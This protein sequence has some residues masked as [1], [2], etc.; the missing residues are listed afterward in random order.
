MKGFLAAGGIVFVSLMSTCDAQA[1]G[2]PRSQPL[3]CAGPW[4][5]EEGSLQNA[6]RLVKL[7]DGREPED[8][9]RCGLR[10]LEQLGEVEPT[11]LCE[12]CR[13]EYVGLLDDTADYLGKAAL[14]TQSTNFR[15]ALFKQEIET[16]LSLAAFLN[17]SE[18]ER[19]IKKFWKRNFEGLGDAL[20]RTNDAGRFVAQARLSDPGLMGYRSFETWSRAVRS[21]S[22]WNFRSAEKMSKKAIW[23]NT[24]SEDCRAD[25][26]RIRQRSE[27]A[28]ERER[29]NIAELLDDRLPRVEECSG[30]ER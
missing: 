13:A 11:E 8:R 9:A 14:R 2:G 20:D 26:A 21:C 27:L 6:R 25:V 28:R 4:T 18:D 1:A 15:T 30:D 19:L 12:H 17:D 23:S 7:P 5:F 16:R 22:A 29:R 10:A 24:C 3:G